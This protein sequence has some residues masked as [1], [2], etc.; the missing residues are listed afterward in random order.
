M[1]KRSRGPSRPGQQRPTRRPQRP[2]GRTVAPTGTV[3]PVRGATALTEAEEA[4]AAELEAQIMA[5]ERTSV[6]GRSRRD[7]GAAAAALPSRARSVDTSSLLAARAAEE[8][9]YVKRDVR[10]IGMVGGGMF[11][12]MLVLFVLIEVVH[13]ITI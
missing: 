6:A 3:E 10:R 12:I 5:Q 1:A 8:Y 2:A 13:V 4:R 11:A 7:R 9:A